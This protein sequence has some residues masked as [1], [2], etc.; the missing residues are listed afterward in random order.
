M[1]GA[2]QGTCSLI[3]LFLFYTDN[4]LDNSLTL[5]QPRALIGC[6]VAGC[7]WEAELEWKLR[8]STT[9]ALG[10]GYAGLGLSPLNG[11]FNVDMAKYDISEALIIYFSVSGQEGWD[12]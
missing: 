1:P 5:S 3:H 8:Q 10:C 2:S 4:T 6:H 11:M 9:T 7:C 12:N